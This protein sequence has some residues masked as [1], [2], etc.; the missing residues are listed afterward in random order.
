M[1]NWAESNLRV[2]LSEK[3]DFRKP[4]IK[5]LQESEVILKK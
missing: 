1:D 3:L 2:K 4:S 5:L